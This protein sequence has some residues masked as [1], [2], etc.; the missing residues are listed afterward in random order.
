MLVAT[1]GHAVDRRNWDLLR[2]LYLPDAVDDHSPYYCGPAS[3]FINALPGIMAAWAAT[4][5]TALSCLFVVEGDEAQGEIAA[6]AWHLTS[7]GS[8]QF[9][10]WGRYADHYRCVDGIWRFAKRAFILDYAE[11]L[12][13]TQGDDFGSDG[14][15]VGRAGPDDPVYS[16]LSWFA[17]R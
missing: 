2:T 11:D 3:G 13:G 6:R 9:V 12:P 1:Y 14:V 10:A 4:M 5:H 8:R 15:A 16:R 7:D 17:R